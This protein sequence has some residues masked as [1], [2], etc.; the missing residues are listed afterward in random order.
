MSVCLLA[1]LCKN[2]GTYL[3]EIFREVGNGPVNRWFNFGFGGDPDPYRDTGKTYLGG[4]MLLVHLVFWCFLLI[5]GT[6]FFIDVCCLRDLTCAKL[7]MVWL[8]KN[9]DGVN[10][11]SSSVMLMW[12]WCASISCILLFISEFRPFFGLLT[13]SCD[14]VVCTDLDHVLHGVS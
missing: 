14:T 6:P 3:H 2:F 9:Q 8:Y 12:K 1:T 10:I 5:M 13:V 4:G 7:D 11:D